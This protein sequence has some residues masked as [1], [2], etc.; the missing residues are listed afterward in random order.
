MAGGRR[1]K[2]DREQNTLAPLALIIIC[3]QT[4]GA[5]NGNISNKLIGSGCE[6]AD[7]SWRGGAMSGWFCKLCETVEVVYSVSQQS[8]SN[9][10]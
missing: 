5:T 3:H 10:T 7:G 8:H 9:S 4:G 6:S 2:D 1:G